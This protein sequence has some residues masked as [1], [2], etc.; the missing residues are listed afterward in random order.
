MSQQDPPLREQLGPRLAQVG[1]LWRAE[2]DRQ[3]SPYGLTAARWRIL[4]D[5]S[6]ARQ[7]LMQKELAESI[8]VQGPTLVRSLD[9]LEAEGLVERRAIA[10]DRRAKTVHL[11]SRAEPALA[12]IQA[13]VTRIGM[14]I[15]EGIDPDDIAVCLN[16]FDQIVAKLGGSHFS[17][18]S[19]AD[20][21]NRGNTHD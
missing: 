20:I 3:L 7:P 19:L 5:L 12:Q 21:S 17:S 15:F 10:G 18:E 9:W 13:V 1:R 14:H 6:R 8:G 11:T 4:M 16:V 2:I